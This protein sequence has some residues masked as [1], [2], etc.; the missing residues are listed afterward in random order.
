MRIRFYIERISFER[1][2]FLFNGLLAFIFYH[3]VIRKKTNIWLFGSGSGLFENNIECFFNYCADIK[4]TNAQCI[5]VTNKDNL[6]FSIQTIKKGSFNAYLKGFQAEVLIFDTANSDIIPGFLNWASGFKVNLSHGQEGFKR[7]PSNY[8]KNIKADVHC[9]VSTF[10]KNIKI[11][12]CGACPSS[13]IVTGQPRYDAIK[14]EDGLGDILL[15]LTWREGFQN[16]SSDELLK[17]QYIRNIL[18]I[19]ESSNILGILERYD[20]NLYIK[21]H[22]MLPPIDLGYT[23]KRIV[24]LDEHMDFST[25]IR[26]C[27]ILITD[28][29][30]VSW[31]YIYNNRSVIFYPFD[32]K[33]Y[34][35][36]PGLYIDLLNEKAMDSVNKLKDLE[37]LLESKLIKNIEETSIFST[38]TPN[39]YFEYQDSNNCSRIYDLIQK[40]VK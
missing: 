10:E 8:Y 22:H 6:N 38:L 14:R 16:M 20:K 11:H 27:S 19:I 23:H 37:A 40:A 17:T 4:D 24:F 2:L 25:T 12:E 7:L 30:S 18:Q 26:E 3:L 32:Y 21:F 31:D 29:S 34:S 33:E 5:F 15:F 35:H 36:S 39:K 13:V 9:A 1:I 28:Y